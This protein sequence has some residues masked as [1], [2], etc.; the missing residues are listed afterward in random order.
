[1]PVSVVECDDDESQEEEEEEEEQ[2]PA[3][4]DPQVEEEERK[5]KD[6]HSSIILKLDGSLLEKEKLLAAI[7]QS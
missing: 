5:L 4:P 7:K 6:A 1:M 2:I 3:Q